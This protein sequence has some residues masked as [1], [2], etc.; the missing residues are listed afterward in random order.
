MSEKRSTVVISRAAFIKSFKRL[1][2]VVNKQKKF[3]KDLTVLE[4]T[5]TDGVLA[6]AVPGA[7]L[8]IEGTT[9]GTC[10]ATIRYFYFLQ[11]IEDSAHKTIEI[12]IT[13]GE[14]NINGVRKNISTTFFENDS[15]LRTINLPANYRVIDLLRL[16][17]EGFTIEELQ[18][19]VLDIPLQN[20]KMM[21]KGNI[22]RSYSNLS[23]YGVTKEDI[24]ELVEK[25][26]R[27]KI[28]LEND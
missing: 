8:R 22:E 17:S 1:A 11:M 23:D 27:I 19:N 13:Q 26:G 5:V 9:S 24:I 14:I 28:D 18:F 2:A 16:P 21:L 12:E 7:V 3:Y 20:A 6:L 4:L 10:K 25:R 15:I